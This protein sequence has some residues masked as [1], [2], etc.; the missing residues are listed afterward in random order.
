MIRPP[1]PGAGTGLR[2][3]DQAACFHRVATQMCARVLRTQ[4]PPTEP[5]LFLEASLRTRCRLGFPLVRTGARGVIRK[6]Q[7]IVRSKPRL[8]V[9]EN[10]TQALGEMNR[11]LMRA[12]AATTERPHSAR[13][14]CR[15]RQGRES[16]TDP[17]LPGRILRKVRRRE[18]C[19]RARPRS[20]ARSSRSR[21][22]PKRH[23]SERPEAHLM[24]S[25]VPVC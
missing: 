9:A 25:P 14:T 1:H 22:R 21:W 2:V 3:A 7:V 11:S 20:L 10:Q 12:G 17:G 23:R 19:L 16:P 4:W 6:A 24:R 15:R 18:R 8:P 5:A 13:G